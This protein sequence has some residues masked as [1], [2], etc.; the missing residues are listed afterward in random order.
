T[1][2]AQA[3]GLPSGGREPLASLVA[4]LKPL[5]VLLAIDNAEHLQQAVA[6][7]AQAIMAGAPGVRL[8]VT[9]QLALKVNGERVFRL[10]PLSVPETGASLEAA[11]A[12]GAVAL[13][14]DQARAADR[15]FT[16]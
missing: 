2:V 13:F 1:V 15:R 9:S 7:L 14:V 4:A 16:V 5:Q 6:E 8:L 12:H 10:H 11:L 3:L